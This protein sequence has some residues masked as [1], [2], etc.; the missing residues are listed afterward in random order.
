[1]LTTFFRVLSPLTRKLPWRFLP[2]SFRKGN[3]DLFFGG[4]LEISGSVKYDFTSQPLSL[5]IYTIIVYLLASII[6]K[7]VEFTRRL[8]HCAEVPYLIILKLFLFEGNK[9]NLYISPQ[10]EDHRREIC[11]LRVSLCQ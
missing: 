2:L 11:F 7:R 8:L 9:L 4:N 1:M 3:W 10:R 5:P 6:G